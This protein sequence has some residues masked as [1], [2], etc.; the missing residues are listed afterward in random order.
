VVNAV[1]VLTGGRAVSASLDG[2]LRV[3]DLDS[4]KA[5][6]VMTLDAPVLTV[7]AN[8]DGEIIV[9]GDRSGRVHF[10]DLVEPESLRRAPRAPAGLKPTFQTSSE[11][12]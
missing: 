7:A 6:A 9:A 4:G 12:R 8:P 2:T 1:A 11:R 3:W 5:L 10:F